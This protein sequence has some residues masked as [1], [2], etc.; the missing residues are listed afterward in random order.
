MKVI[1]FTTHSVDLRIVDSKIGKVIPI[2]DIAKA[3]DYDVKA[4]KQ[5]IERNS[6]LFEGSLV[7]VTTLSHFEQKLKNGAV[8]QRSQKF[9][10]K[11][12]NSYGVYGLLMK[13][14]YNR[15]QDE[16]KKKAVLRFQRW[17]MEILASHDIKTSK[18]T[19]RAAKRKIIKVIHKGYIDRDP[20]APESMELIKYDAAAE[21][22]GISTKTL[23]RYVNKGLI[24]RY[25]GSNFNLEDIKII[26]E[27]KKV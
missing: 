3:I 17:A 24:Q 21:M 1:P 7:P 19:K 13:L 23:Q 25:R 12:L 16:D 6:E 5:M 4:L 8:Q 26:A 27:R 11:A 15:I 14:D 9:E 10:V 22:I 2:V 18:P 20:I